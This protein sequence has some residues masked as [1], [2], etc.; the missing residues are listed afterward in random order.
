MENEPVVRF[1][2]L[3]K[4]EKLGVQVKLDYANQLRALVRTKFGSY[5]DASKF[6]TINHVSISKI[7]RRC[8]RIYNWIK[9]FELLNLD[10]NEIEE[11]IIKVADKKIYDI[12][13][14]YKVSPLLIR[15]AAHI[16]GDGGFYNNSGRWI[17]K[18]VEPIVNLQKQILGISGNKS[19]NENNVEQVAIMSFYTKLVC[20]ALKI[21][22][23]QLRSTD[24]IKSCMKLPREY[25][26][27]VVA[28][29]IEDE[30]RIEAKSGS[31]QIAMK[32][33]EIVN[34]FAELMD[35]LDYDRSNVLKIKNKSFNSDEESYLFSVHLRVLGAHKFYNDLKLAMDKYGKLAGLWKKQKQLEDLILFNDGRKARGEKLNSELSVKT[36]GLMKKNNGTTTYKELK[37]CLGT[38]HHRT[39]SVVRR[40]Y[41]KRIINKSQRGY[42][43]LV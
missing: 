30:S 34:S 28:A 23:N 16:I 13:F 10:L 38:S 20:A 4:Y 17:Q 32:N 42:Y 2:D 1:H 5:K 41:N 8:T 43:V 15:L 19:R 12:N 29:I 3:L 40:L 31:I 35:N 24:F 27:Q 36:I 9:I 37:Q 7:E 11:H 14:P 22:R 18:D 6:S 39:G 33:F 25:Q 21:E 26:V